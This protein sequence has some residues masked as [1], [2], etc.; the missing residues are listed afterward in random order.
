M[1]PPAIFGAR[2]A[3]ATS[4]F[5]PDG[6]KI[7]VACDFTGQTSGPSGGFNGGGTPPPNAGDILEYTYVG[8]VLALGDPHPQERPAE[9]HSIRIYPNPV[10]DLLGVSITTEVQKPLHLKLYSGAGVLMKELTTTRPQV[11]LNLRSLRA[12]LYYLQV[13]NA[14]DR[15][16]RTEKIIKLSGATSFPLR[17][18]S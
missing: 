18:C 10:Q 14:Y 15:L 5:Q 16:I 4:L 2:A 1:I 17:L 11:Q 3:F 12:G 13:Y 8:A 9:D 6:L 7:Y